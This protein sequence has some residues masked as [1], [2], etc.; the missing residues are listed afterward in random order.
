MQTTVTYVVNVYFLCLRYQIYCISIYFDFEIRITVFLMYHFN[1]IRTCKKKKKKTQ[2]PLDILMVS[3]PMVQT[4]S[5]LLYY[6]YIKNFFR[7]DND[8]LG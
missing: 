4:S 7:Y 1:I 2:L 3:M 6:L 5:N 8:K